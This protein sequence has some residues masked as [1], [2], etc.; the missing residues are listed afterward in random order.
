MGSSTVVAEPS[1]DYKII[2]ILLTKKHQT[3]LATDVSV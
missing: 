2:Y 1:G 3:V